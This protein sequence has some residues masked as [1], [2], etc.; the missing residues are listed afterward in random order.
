[1][2]GYFAVLIIV[3]SVVA[4]CMRHAGRISVRRI[5]AISGICLTALAI[6]LGT[7]TGVCVWRRERVQ[8]PEIAMILMAALTFGTTVVY[9]AG[10][11][12]SV[13]ELRQSGVHGVRPCV[14][15]FHRRRRVR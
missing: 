7:L 15:Q 11:E 1:M 2:V 13:R 3:G 12:Q 8:L 4:V 10:K 9:E 6:A 14:G 5:L